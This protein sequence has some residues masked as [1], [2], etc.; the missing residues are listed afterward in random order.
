LRRLFGREDV[1][2]LEWDESAPGGAPGIT[3]AAVTRLAGTASVGG[4]S[5]PWSMIRKRLPRP[6]P[7][8]ERSARRLDPTSNTYW[9]REYNLYR[10]GLLDDLPGGMATP[11]CLGAEETADGCTVWL[12]EI[13]EDLPT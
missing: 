13:Q 7:Q 6:N 1:T 12:E 3:A 4:E 9:Q 10:S 8:D 5:R 11:R 2:V